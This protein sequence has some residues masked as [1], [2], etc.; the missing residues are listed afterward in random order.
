[1]RDWRDLGY[2]NAPWN[3]GFSD[4]RTRAGCDGEGRAPTKAHGCTRAGL[5]AGEMTAGLRFEESVMSS[6]IYTHGS[7]SEAMVSLK[8]YSGVMLLCL[9]ACHVHVRC[10]GFMRR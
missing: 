2:D 9:V 4:A 8:Y 1:M 5:P 7:E 10:P 3:S 6:R